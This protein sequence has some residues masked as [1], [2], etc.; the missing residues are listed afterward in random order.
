[1]K[2]YQLIVLDKDNKVQHSAEEDSVNGAC[3]VMVNAISNTHFAAEH[4]SL[5]VA[6]SELIDKLAVIRDGVRVGDL[7][8]RVIARNCSTF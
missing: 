4:A 6:L 8:S 5:E 2:K 3:R 7:K 1:M